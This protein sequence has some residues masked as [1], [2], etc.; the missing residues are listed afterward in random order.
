MSA[1]LQTT[2]RSVSVLE[3]KQWPAGFYTDVV[4]DYNVFVDVC[5]KKEL[6]EKSF[7]GQVQLVSTSQILNA[8]ADV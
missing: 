5:C 1:A 6:T 2:D 8:G 3:E 7:T 4:A